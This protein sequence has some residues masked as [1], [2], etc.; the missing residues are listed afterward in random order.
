MKLELALAFLNNIKTLLG[1]ATFLVSTVMFIAIA[2]SWMNKQ[3]LPFKIKKRYVAIYVIILCVLCIPDLNELWKV[4]ISLIKLELS[5]PENIA[6]GVETIER[7]GTKL[8]C[9]YLGCEEKK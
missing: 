7:I 2:S 4:R 5:S 6:K 9:K 1:I 3:D 8:E